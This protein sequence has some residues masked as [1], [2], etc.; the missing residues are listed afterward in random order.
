MNLDLRAAGGPVE[1]ASERIAGKL[2]TSWLSEP[3]I[4]E[5]VL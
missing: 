3:S 2:G 4:S 1:R 5:T